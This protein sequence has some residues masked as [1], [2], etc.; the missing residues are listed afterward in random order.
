MNEQAFELLMSM[1]SEMRKDIKELMSFRWKVVGGIVVF[2]LIFGLVAQFVI[3]Y[4]SKQ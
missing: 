3:A 2:N 4:Y 1:I